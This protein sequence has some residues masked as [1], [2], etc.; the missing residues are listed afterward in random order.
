MIRWISYQG[1]GHVIASEQTPA[2]VLLG[3]GQSIEIE[4][5]DDIRET[6]TLHARPFGA[7]TE[8]VCHQQVKQWSLHPDDLPPFVAAALS[9]PKPAPKR[10]DA[11]ARR[12]AIEEANSGADGGRVPPRGTAGRRST[13]EDAGDDLSFPDEGGP[14]AV[15]D[16][17]FV[18]PSAPRRSKRSA[19]DPDDIDI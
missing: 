15:G 4:E 5:G 7:D 14:A 8:D 17:V 3:C 12:K 11:A 6:E 19:P 16:A 13:T 1:Y 18:A 9:E 2:G 10:P